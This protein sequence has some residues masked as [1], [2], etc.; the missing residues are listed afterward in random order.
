M[1]LPIGV[2]SVKYELTGFQAVL[3]EDVRLTAGFTARLDIVL[4][5]GAL[6]ETLTVSGQSPVVDTSSTTGT[7]SFSKETLENAPT[8]RAFAEVL[9][10]APG[11]RPAGV[12]VGGSELSEQRVGVKN[13][14][15]SGQITPQ[16][17]GINTRQASGSAGFFYD[18]SAVEEAQIQGGRQRRRSGAARRRME[19]DRQVGRRRVPRPLL[20]RRPDTGMQSS[21]VD[22]ELRPTASIRT[23]SGMRHYTRRR[24]PISAAAS[25]AAVCGSTRRCTT[26]A[27]R[28]T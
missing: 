27:A 6:T 2:Y 26:S 8:S 19:C 21:N 22:E 3:R 13:Y 16:L 1:D 17:E 14:G 9:S 4:K 23:G 7:V 28:R 15:T 20:V 10:M 11:F 5:V 25:S 24:P 12:D 18:Y